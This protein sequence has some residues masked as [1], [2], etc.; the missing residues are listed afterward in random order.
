MSDRLSLA[1]RITEIKKILTLTPRD[2]LHSAALLVQLGQHMLSEAEL[3]TLPEAERT[4]LYHNLEAGITRLKHTLN[5][6]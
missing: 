4:E 3:A 5:S 1:E 2:R 6:D